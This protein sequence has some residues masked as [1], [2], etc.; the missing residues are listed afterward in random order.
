MNTYFIKESDFDE[1]VN[2]ML[3][4][5]PVIAPMSVKKLFS[6]DFLHL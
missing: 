1:F 3:L 2:N 5:L 4:E 6:F